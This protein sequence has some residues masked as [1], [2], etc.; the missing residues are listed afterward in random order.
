MAD[1]DELSQLEAERDRLLSMIACH[2]GPFDRPLRRL[3][4]GPPMPAWFVMVAIA[5][6]LGIGILIVAGIFA[7]QVS[8]P[9]VLFLVVGLP[10]LA[11]I[12]T[13]RITLFGFS[14][15]VGDALAA[16]MRPDVPLAIPTVR[17]AGEP[18]ALQR[19]AD[20]EARIMKLKEGRSR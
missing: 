6:I 20:C 18:E 17:P 14:F 11:Y 15:L 4:L 1:Q 13:R 7:G 2:G 3:H 5:I 12:L 16:L 9:G 10:L 19:L 8:A